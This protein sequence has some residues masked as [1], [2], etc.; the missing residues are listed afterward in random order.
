MDLLMNTKGL[1]LGLLFE[2]LDIVLIDP[3]FLSAPKLKCWF[4]A[5]QENSRIKSKKRLPPFSLF[6]FFYHNDSAFYKQH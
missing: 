4:P 2:A 1:G 5:W 3:P 6:V